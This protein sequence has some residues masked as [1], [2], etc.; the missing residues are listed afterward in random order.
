MITT[1]TLK[2]VGFPYGQDF[3]RSETNDVSVCEGFVK[4]Y[5]KINSPVVSF[6]V[7]NKRP[8]QRGWY[9]VGWS[10]QSLIK[11]NGELTNEVIHIRLANFLHN[12]C[13][14]N[15]NE[16]QISVFWFRVNSF[17]SK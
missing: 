4:K 13:G 14:V 2:S 11:I 9:R 5:L 15:P 7:S 17:G 1:T 16:Y 6:S 8:H 12:V 3:Y 10:S